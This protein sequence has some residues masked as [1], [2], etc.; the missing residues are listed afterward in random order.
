MSIMWELQPADRG[1][2]AASAPL[3]GGVV[4]RSDRQEDHAAAWRADHVREE[5]RDRAVRSVLLSFG[6]SWSRF[7]VKTATPQGQTAPPEYVP[8]LRACAA[9]LGTE[10]R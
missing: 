9:G 6:C 2:D 10:H 5:P 7:G 4:R 3:L 1:P 8:G